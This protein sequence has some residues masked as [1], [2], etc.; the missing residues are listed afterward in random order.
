MSIYTAPHHSR[1]EHRI[2][3][4]YGGSGYNMRDTDASSVA[5][6]RAGGGGYRGQKLRGGHKRGGSQPYSS[7]MSPIPP[8]EPEMA[9]API[10][11]VSLASHGAATQRPGTDTY[12]TAA[13]TPGPQSEA[14]A[15][16]QQQRPHPGH[17]APPSV[18][19]T[20]KS[21]AYS[22]SRSQSHMQQ[23]AESQDQPDASSSY[24]DDRMQIPAPPPPRSTIHKPAMFISAKRQPST[25]PLGPMSTI[26]AAS[27]APAA[28]A[29]SSSKSSAF[30]GVLPEDRIVALSPVPA[31]VASG[32]SG[33]ASAYEYDFPSPAP[34]S[35]LPNMDVEPIESL[36]YKRTH[37]DGLDAKIGASGRTS[38]LAASS[39][40]YPASVSNYSQG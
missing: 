6:S 5:S 38:G 12:S 31:S 22:P 29:A 16:S 26:S 7:T 28:G 1:Q 11:T 23:I 4:E 30:G 33:A 17:L 34:S 13:S 35:R 15:S 14:G 20:L 37:N 25:G 18:S 10:I 27:A 8:S 19:S 24:G 9:D 36:L 40:G 2:D 21:H 3:V 39:V 32:N